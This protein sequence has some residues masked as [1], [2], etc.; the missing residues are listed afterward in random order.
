MI[1]IYIYLVSVTPQCIRRPVRHG[2]LHVQ[3]DIQ[4]A[5]LPKLGCAISCYGSLSSPCYGCCQLL[6]NGRLTPRYDVAISSYVEQARAF[7]FNVQ[8]CIILSVPPLPPIINKSRLASCYSKLCR[9]YYV[10]KQKAPGSPITFN[11]SNIQHCIIISILS[12][13]SITSMSRLA[14]CD[15]ILWRFDHV[16]KQKALGYFQQEQHLALCHYL[17]PVKETNKRKGLPLSYEN[18][19]RHRDQ[20]YGSVKIPLSVGRPQGWGFQVRSFV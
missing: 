10:W 14:P 8:H 16:W 17:R 11:M 2:H 3:N 19:S 7:H 13:P 1:F 18:I 20:G 9:F 5:I 15:S 4:A 6:T 12:L